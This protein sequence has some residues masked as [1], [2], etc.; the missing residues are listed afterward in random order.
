MRKTMPAA[1]RPPKKPFWNAQTIVVVVLGAIFLTCGVLYKTGS[2]ASREAARSM[3]VTVTGCR[4]SGASLPAATIEFTVTNSGS[5]ARGATL[6][7]EYRD[8]SGARIDTDTARVQT[9]APGD[10][11]KGSE[12]TILDAQVFGAITCKITNVS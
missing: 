7:V 12:T 4:T 11:A 2:S 6:A 1:E 3:K 9:I 10:T 8:E 5:T